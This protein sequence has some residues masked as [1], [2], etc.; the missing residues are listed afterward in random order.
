VPPFAP[1]TPDPSTPTSR[2]RRSHARRCHARREY[3]L[4][5]TCR[6]RGLPKVVI[7]TA[8]IAG[9][10]FD[11]RVDGGEPALLEAH[12]RALGFEGSDVSTVFKNLQ[13][14]IGA[15]HQ[16]MDFQFR[17]TGPTTANLA[18]ALRRA[19]GTSSRSA[20]SACAQCATTSKIRRSTPPRG[21]PSVHEDAPE[22]TGRRAKPAHRY[23]HCRWAVFMTARARRSS[24]TRTRDRVGLEGG[25]RGDRRAARDG[26]PGGWPGLLG[27]VRSRLPARRSLA[28]RARDRE[29]GVRGA[30]PPAR[31][32]LSCSAARRRFG[33]DA[34][35][36]LAEAQWTG[37]PRD[38][39]AAA[40]ADA[41]RRRRH[42]GDREDLLGPPVLLPAQLTS[43]SV[44]ITGPRSAR[45]AIGDCPRSRRAIRT[46]GSPD[47]ALRRT[48]ARRDRGCGEPRARCHPVENPKDA[49]LAWD[50]VIDR[51]G[52][53]AEE[54]PELKLARLSRAQRS[55]SSSGAGCGIRRCDELPRPLRSRD[56]TLHGVL[57]ARPPRSPTRPT[58]GWTTKDLVRRGRVPRERVA[59]ARA[60]SGSRAAI[61]SRSCCSERAGIVYATFGCLSLGAI[62]IP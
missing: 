50:V 53:A 60:S 38:C 21:N 14:D 23:P 57:A 13:L 36:E 59:A 3:L 17:S 19:D 46:R 5:A 40:R 24:S 43:T 48:R 32:A 33:D 7:R 34:A 22:S 27:P 45:I 31:R 58:S 44:E 10:D 41:D 18:V 61:R 49:R 4:N 55:G 30:E 26:E 12:Q 9:A 25:E 42:R 15:P 2:S 6:S 16:F 47:C 28:P 54:P 39:E 11:R 8:S 37:S 52:R 56:R 29:P 1:T 35:S 51:G 20:K 62:W